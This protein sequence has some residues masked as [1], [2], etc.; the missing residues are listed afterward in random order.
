MVS[1]LF[2]EESIMKVKVI[3]LIGCVVLTISAGISMRIGIFAWER[4]RLGFSERK[5]L[6]FKTY[7][8]LRVNDNELVEIQ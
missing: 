5:L 2:S 4:G 8:E 1:E 3:Y 6:N 7:S